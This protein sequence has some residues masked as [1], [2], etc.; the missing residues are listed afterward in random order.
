MRVKSL[1]SR[2]AIAGVMP[3]TVKCREV[4]DP[5]CHRRCV[6]Q[7]AEGCRDSSLTKLRVA[8]TVETT[9]FGS[10]AP[11][12]VVGTG[13]IEGGNLLGQ[14]DNLVKNKNREVRRDEEIPYRKNQSSIAHR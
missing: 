9:L 13:E 3:R 6:F 14:R 1:S 10:L 5:Y 12:G 4:T 7:V 2:G 8:A 11:T